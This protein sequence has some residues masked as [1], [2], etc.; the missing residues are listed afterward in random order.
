ME[1]RDKGKKYIQCAINITDGVAIASSLTDE[2]YNDRENSNKNKNG[3][4]SGRRTETTKKELRENSNLIKSLGSIVE[5]YIAM[6]RE[7][8]DNEKLT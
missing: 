7:L 6:T 2:R 8:K 3:R 5:Q 4:D 1:H